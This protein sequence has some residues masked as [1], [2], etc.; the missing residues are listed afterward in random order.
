MLAQTVA[1]L[2][3]ASGALATYSPQA[4]KQLRDLRQEHVVVEVRQAQSS[5]ATVTE[6]GLSGE[7][8]SS[9]FSLITAAPTPPPALE[10]Y[11][12]SFLSTADLTNPSILCQASQDVPQSLSADFSS[13]DQQAS[14]WLNAH[15]SQI[16]DLASKCAGDSNA[17]VVSSAVSVLEAYISNGCHGTGSPGLAARPTGMVAGAV[18]AAGMLGVAVML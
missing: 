10:S 16:N 1:I 7:C 9:A 5:G 11:F 12:D 13:Y 4:L 3:L 2:G 17:P 14:S 18:A 6:T 15:T 8:T